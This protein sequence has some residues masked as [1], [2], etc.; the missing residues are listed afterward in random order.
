MYRS[1]SPPPQLFLLAYAL[2]TSEPRRRRSALSAAGGERN[3]IPACGECVWDGWTPALC[4]CLTPSSFTLPTHKG[5]PRREGREGSLGTP[6][7]VAPGAS[8]G[9]VSPGHP[10][11]DTTATDLL[12]GLPEQKNENL[13]NKN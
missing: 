11:S 13:Q 4:L 9:L 12:A 6:L 10:H 3:V 7:N 1:V 5:D 8:P 2:E